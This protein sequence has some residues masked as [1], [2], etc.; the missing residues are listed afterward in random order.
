[1]ETVLIVPLGNKGVLGETKDS[2]ITTFSL[3]LTYEDNDTLTS[4]ASAAKMAGSATPARVSTAAPFAPNDEITIS[5]FPASALEG[6][7]SPL[8]EHTIDDFKYAISVP[9]IAIVKN[10]LL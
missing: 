3:P 1:M 4:V 9:L 7:M 10:G 5:S 6:R 2:V 8:I